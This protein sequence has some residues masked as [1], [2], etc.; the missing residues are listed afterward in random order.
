MAII[1]SV[2][3]VN[4]TIPLAFRHLAYHISILVNLPYWVC[5]MEMAL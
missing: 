3:V 4:F 5:A 1:H 2:L